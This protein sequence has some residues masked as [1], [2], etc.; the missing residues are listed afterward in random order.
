MRNTLP[1]EP[2]ETETGVSHAILQFSFHAKLY[3]N[4]PQFFSIQEKLIA[5]RMRIAELH[6]A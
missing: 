4:Y 2:G 6:Q 3:S 5:R 1:S